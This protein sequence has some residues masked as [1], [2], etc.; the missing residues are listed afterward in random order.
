MALPTL[1]VATPLGFRVWNPRDQVKVR[2]CHTSHLHMSCGYIGGVPRPPWRPRP[3]GGLT[4]CINVS[5][6]GVPEGEEYER[7]TAEPYRGTLT[8][9][10]T[11]NVPR[12][13]TGLGSTRKAAVALPNAQRAAGALSFE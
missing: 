2:V 8:V 5:L 4:P 6:T 3:A 1:A 10:A 11:V 13:G 9:G 12:P 7:K